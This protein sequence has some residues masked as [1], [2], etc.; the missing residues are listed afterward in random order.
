MAVKCN[1]HKHSSGKGIAKGATRLGRGATRQH[2][3][4]PQ[5]KGGDQTA[6]QEGFC[7]HPSPQEQ[8]C[9]RLGF[10][11]QRLRSP[12]LPGA[13]P[14]IA[15]ASRS[16]TCDRP[17]P[18][19]ANCDRPGFPVKPCDLQQSRRDC[20]DRPSPREL[21]SCDYEQ[22]RGPYVTSQ[23]QLCLSATMRGPEGT[24]RV[25]VLSH[26]PREAY[27]HTSTSTLPQVLG[28]HDHAWSYTTIGA[29]TRQKWSHMI[30]VDSH[31]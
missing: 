11:E 19:G 2:T 26:N 7:D 29:N 14:A 31:H 8:A 5:S 9:D 10:Q 25:K 3:G 28:L 24:T 12:R 16:K 22:S 6:V 23:N 18:Q 20:C 17:G 1:P 27:E 13:K 15:Q 30:S 4:R 21:I